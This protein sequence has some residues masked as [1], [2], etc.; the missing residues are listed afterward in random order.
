MVHSKT[1]NRRASL[2]ILAVVACLAAITGCTTG[3]PSAT[4]PSGMKP[5]T[6]VS[7]TATSSADAQL[8]AECGGLGAPKAT[9]GEAITQNG[10]QMV[11]IA[12]AGGYYVPNR[13]TAKAGVPI[14][15]VFTGNAKGCVAKPKFTSLGK[16]G[17][18]TGIGTTTID[19][20]ALDAGTYEFSCAMGANKGTVTVQ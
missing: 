3:T 13:I 8:C 9:A 18:V 6:S 19:L 14:R 11:S 17:D 1:R 2:A 4:Q 15:V 7:A 16:S 5:V 20:G 10:V 12:I